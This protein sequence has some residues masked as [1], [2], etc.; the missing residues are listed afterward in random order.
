MKKLLI[1][2]LLSGCAALAL[3][4]EDVPKDKPKARVESA[5]P[6]SGVRRFEA[7]KFSEEEL[8]ALEKTAAKFR[9]RLQLNR[10]EIDILRAQT[11]KLLLSK[12]VDLEQIR[13]L[14]KKSL[15]FELDI[16]MAEIE[17]QID[18]RKLLGDERWAVLSRH[19]RELKANFKDID[20]SAYKG[21]DLR[22]LLIYRSLIQP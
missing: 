14:V 5:K 20:E 10:A 13:V 15:E 7:L 16:R 8:T 18:L 2:L 9:D 22:S 19:L 4:A 21:N 17:R 3:F 6:E 1:V 11:G 12:Q